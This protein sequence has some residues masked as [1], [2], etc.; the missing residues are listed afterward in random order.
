MACGLTPAQIGKGEFARSDVMIGL[1]IARHFGQNPITFL[2]ELATAPAWLVDLL[3][4]YVSV[5]TASR[6]DV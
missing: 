6:S 5:D 2:R 3:G 4:W 1:D